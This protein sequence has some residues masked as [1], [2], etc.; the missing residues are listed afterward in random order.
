MQA[1]VL[2][3]NNH[4]ITQIYL[5]LTVSELLFLHSPSH[6]GTHWPFF[7][8]IAEATISYLFHI[9]LQW[10]PFTLHSKCSFLFCAYFFQLFIKGLSGKSY[11]VLLIQMCLFLTAII[12]SVSVKYFTSP[13][14]VQHSWK[15]TECTTVLS[16]EHFHFVPY[17]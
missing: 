13:S 2:E 1:P 6:T 10:Y 11:P 3:T 16:P 15:D 4:S 12:Y 17:H 14:I 8:S 5:F 7:S 9:E